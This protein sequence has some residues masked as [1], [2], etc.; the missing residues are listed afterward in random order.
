MRRSRATAEG[1]VDDPA[2]GHAVPEHRR[3]ELHWL[4]RRVL[5]VRGGFGTSNTL[6][7]ALSPYQPSRAQARWNAWL[8]EHRGRLAWNAEA[9]AFVPAGGAN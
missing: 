2:D 4:H 9:G 3:D 5:L 1:L 8:D 7:C 6:A